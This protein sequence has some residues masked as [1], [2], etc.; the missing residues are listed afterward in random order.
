MISLGTISSQSSEAAPGRIF[1]IGT[2]SGSLTINGA[3]IGDGL[4]A[5]DI[6]LV[7]PGA[8]NNVTIQNFDVGGGYA[9]VNMVGSS[10]GG[11]TTISN[12]VGLNLVG[13]DY[14]GNSNRAIVLTPGTLSDIRIHGQSFKD[15]SDYTLVYD[16]NSYSGSPAQNIEIFDQSYDNCAGMMFQGTVSLPST[17]T[18]RIDGLHVY[19]IHF[20]NCNSTSSLIQ[21]QN[22]NGYNIHHVT[23]KDCVDEEVRHARLIHMAGEGDIHDIKA[24]D[25]YGNI[26]AQWPFTRNIESNGLCRIWNIIGCN[27]S[28][29]SLSEIQA[30]A[31]MISNG[32][33]R[34]CNCIIGHLTGINL[35]DITDLYPAVGVDVYLASFGGN[36]NITVGNSV[37]VNSTMPEGNEFRGYHFVINNVNPELGWDDITHFGNLPY[38]PSNPNG[39]LNDPSDGYDSYTDVGIGDLTDYIPLSSSILKGAGTAMAGLELDYYGTERVNPPSIGAVEAE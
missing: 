21:G 32:I 29:Y 14:D 20:Q 1:N 27:C 37:I 34:H 6:V 28:K 16:A 30:F 13:G 18:G 33:T 12:S 26:A 38:N 36:S 10:I 17:D 31:P 8:Y 7:E 11:L 25:Y 9:T 2:G 19:D 3:T 24:E 39:A 22:V 15:V 5:N 35:N 23:I 4:L